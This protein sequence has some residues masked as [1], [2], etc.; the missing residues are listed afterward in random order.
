LSEEKF[1]HNYLYR[2][3]LLAKLVKEE[4][5]N[6]PAKPVDQ[7]QTSAQS[8]SQTPPQAAVEE[9]KNE[10]QP[11]E[12]VKKEAEQKPEKSSPSVTLNNEFSNRKIFRTRK[13]GKRNF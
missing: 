6:E 12:A 7:P 9:P 1:W 4:T 2:I 11:E 10:S 8:V 3:S 5:A 13:I